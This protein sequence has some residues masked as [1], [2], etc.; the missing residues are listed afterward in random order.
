M[1]TTD[2]RPLL[3]QVS[4]PSVVL[5][6][7]ADAMVPP[8]VGDHLQ[9]HLAGSTVVRMQAIGHC[10]HVSAPEETAAAIRDHLVPRG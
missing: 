8:S 5:Q 2:Y 1:F 4:T 3:P 9:A 10:P 6:C 7:R